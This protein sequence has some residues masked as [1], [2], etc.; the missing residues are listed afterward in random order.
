MVQTLKMKTFTHDNDCNAY[1]PHKRKPSS[2][3]VQYL[4]QEM[5]LK[6]LVSCMPPPHKPPVAFS[7]H[8]VSKGAPK[9]QR[10]MNDK[11]YSWGSQPPKKSSPP[12]KVV[13]PKLI[14]LLGNHVPNLPLGQGNCINIFYFYICSP[15]CKHKGENM[16]KSRQFVIL[17]TKKNKQP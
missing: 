14:L 6:F 16:V 1:I 13:W 5:H 9:K 4:F 10:M 12:T 7:L 2:D 3:D 17:V 8:C 11:K 15:S